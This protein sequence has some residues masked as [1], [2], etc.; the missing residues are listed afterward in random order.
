MTGRVREVWGDAVPGVSDVASSALEGGLGVVSDSARGAFLGVVNGGD[1]SGGGVVDNLGE[2]W[3]D[4]RR[5]YLGDSVDAVVGGVADALEVEARAR[6]GFVRTIDLEYRSGLGERRS[7]EIAAAALGPLR[8]TPDSVLLWQLRLFSADEGSGGNAGLLYRAALD[9]VMAGANVF[10]DYAAT[11][12]Y[13]DFWRYGFGAE[14]RSAWAD[15]FFN[16]YEPLSDPRLATTT[17]GI[18]LG[19]DGVAS[20]GGWAYTA[21]GFDAELHLHSP[22][23]RWLA[24]VLSYYSWA[25]EMG[26]ADETG[27][28]YGVLMRPPFAPNLQMEA[29]Y[30]SP[31][32]GDDKFGGR[33]SYR[34]DLGT[35]AAIARDSGVYDPRADFYLAARRDYA[36]RIRVASGTAA[37][38]GTEARL[39]RAE[40][41]SP[42][43]AALPAESQ[44]AARILQGGHTLTF[45]AGG[46]ALRITGGPNGTP[47]TVSHGEAAVAADS[48]TLP[49]RPALSVRAESPAATPGGAVFEIGPAAGAVATVRAFGAGELYARPGTDSVRVAGNVQIVESPTG[50]GVPDVRL[51]SGVVEYSC[52]GGYCGSFSSDDVEARLFGDSN[53]SSR[54]SSVGTGDSDAPAS[55]DSARRWSGGI[56]RPAAGAAGRGVGVQPPTGGNGSALI[57]GERDGGT[58]VTRLTVKRGRAVVY[59]RSDDGLSQVRMTVGCDFPAD[60]LAN[61]RGGGCGCGRA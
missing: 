57:R 42:L 45:A 1:V 2:W 39:V 40:N 58:G 34:L 10:L 17:G 21:G 54:R 33:V 36:Q 15:L 46:A 24:G 14:L 3:G 25:G 51:E 48:Y 12:D 29:E 28:R 4:Y 41:M 19:S 18:V 43:I 20:S 53:Y 26:Q 52:L 30:D 44:L 60:T 27:L 5:K 8:A 11:D 9:G 61:L 31:E 23:V 38:G 59:S 47:F 7:G 32:S 55:G 49:I 6:F 35:E 50:G 22:D 56:A 13:G 16:K 37:V